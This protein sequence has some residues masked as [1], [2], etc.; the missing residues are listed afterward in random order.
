MR[1][2]LR[3]VGVPYQ[4]L[5]KMKQNIASPRCDIKM[6]CKKIIFHS[7]KHFLRKRSICIATG[8]TIYFSMILLF[9]CHNFFHF[10]TEN[11]YRDNLDPYV[12]KRSTSFD[13]NA[14]HKLE[15]NQ[16]L[17]PTYRQHRKSFCLTFNQLNEQKKC[18]G[19]L[20]TKN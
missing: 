9:N 14:H 13:D 1:I 7:T 17:L 18:Y 2:L 10:M 3:H 19:M 20:H 12:V 5:I 6:S 15:S 8:R 4:L 11:E 16:K